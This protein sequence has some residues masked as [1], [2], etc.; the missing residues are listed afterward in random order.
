MMRLDS[1]GDS[2]QINPVF[3]EQ[4][5]FALS[6]LKHLSTDEHSLY[7][8]H[9]HF[10]LNKNHLVT[11]LESRTSIYRLEAY[12]SWL[13]DTPH[14]LDPIIDLNHIQHLRGVQKI[15]VDTPRADTTQRL[16][17][18]PK[19]LTSKIRDLAKKAI[20]NGLVD[21]PSMNEL[22][23]DHIISARLI[24]ELDDPKYAERADIAKVYS[25]ILKPVSDLDH[26]TIS[27]RSG[28]KLAKGEDLLLTKKIEISI[29]ESR[30]SDDPIEEK[31]LEAAMIQFLNEIK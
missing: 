17:E 25:A 6:Q 14:R 26:Y 2:P 10:C 24:V 9:Y 30:P 29:P 13:F 4:N 3:F 5:K 8:S 18:E 12:L 1:T 16:I 19:N 27:T 22:L 15:T 31:A 28:K 21:A 20:K 23:L 7:K 11:D